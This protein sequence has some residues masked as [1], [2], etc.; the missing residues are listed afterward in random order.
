MEIGDGLRMC[1]LG[2]GSGGEA[3]R[4][5]IEIRKRRMRVEETRH[6]KRGVEL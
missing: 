2:V 6:H 1:G 5:W 4:I 3:E